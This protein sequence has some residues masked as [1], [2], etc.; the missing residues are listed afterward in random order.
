MS[1]E[2]IVVAL[3]GGPEGEVLLRRAAGI[4]GRGAGGELHSVYVARPAPGGAPDPAGLAR[5]RALTEHLGGTHHTPTTT[6]V[7]S[8]P[9]A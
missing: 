9:R 5:L 8:M 2:R 1:P 3:T 6:W 7:A 4:A